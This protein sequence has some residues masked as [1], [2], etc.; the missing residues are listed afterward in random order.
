M[1]KRQAHYCERIMQTIC[2][3]IAQGKTLKVACAKAG[4][5][6]P[7][8]KTVWKWRNESPAIDEMYQ[9]ALDAAARAR[10]EARER[11][12]GKMIQRITKAA[13]SPIP[14]R[15]AAHWASALFME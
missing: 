7:N 4:P 2:D 14:A 5:L 3:Y 12:E 1:K 9:A 11:E 15:P 8:A 6:A 10:Q 13:T